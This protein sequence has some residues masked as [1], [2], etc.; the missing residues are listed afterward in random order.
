MDGPINSVSAINVGAGTEGFYDLYGM[1]FN[2]LYYKDLLKTMDSGL[3]ST[4]C[5][6]WTI[7]NPEMTS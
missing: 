3:S 1:D 2:P 4:A 7:R 6:A 5:L